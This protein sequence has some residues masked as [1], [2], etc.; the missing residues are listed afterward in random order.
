MSTSV[1][2]RDPA[3]AT[4]AVVRGP[5]SCG[6]RGARTR[7]GGSCLGLAMAN[8]RCRI[9][10]GASTGPRTSEGLARMVAAKTTHG[11]FATSSALG[12]LRQRH[13]RTLI[14]RI[15]LTDAASRL[16][17]YLPAGMAA[18]LDVGPEELRAPKHPSQEAFEALQEAAGRTSVPAPLGLGRR[19]RAAWARLGAG[20][21]VADAAAA[22]ALH[23]RETERLAMRAETASQAPWRTAIAAA[24]GLRQAV[25]EEMRRQIRD[26]R[27]DPMGGVSGRQTPDRCN[28]PI[29]GASGRQTSDGRNDPMGGASGRQ[30]ADRRNDPMGGAAAGAWAVAAGG[31]T[32]SVRNDPMGG[33]VVP[34]QTAGV[35]QDARVGMPAERGARETAGWAPGSPGLREALA[36]EL[37]RRRLR[38]AAGVRGND[39]IGGKLAG[40][41][42]GNGGR[43]APAVTG[44]GLMR[45][46]ALGG[47][48]LARTWEPGVAEV[49][50]AR[51]GPAVVEGW[52]RAPG[53]PLGIAAMPSGGCAQR[54][55]RRSGGLGADG[56]WVTG[57]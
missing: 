13:A 57:R 35:P 33:A 50:G 27:N 19:S 45:S 56:G 15:R 29:G 14:D 2:V 8:G 36:R 42:A 52:A 20:G 21:G 32:R 38:A 7:A 53:V 44:S 12:R 26:R 37:E 23:G 1:V 43:V 10:G 31:Q 54:P 51:V 5:P 28:D 18:R 9:H 24:R 17:V 55:Y 40:A 46:L 6:A 30:T 34:A 47:T 25:G 22:V 4:T 16:Q 49:L 39:P 11:R 48:P 41:G 3:A